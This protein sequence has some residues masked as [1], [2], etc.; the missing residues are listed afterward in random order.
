V[1][2][3]VTASVLVVDDDFMVAAVNAGYLERMPG[4]RVAGV[5][6]S[7]REA[8]RRTDELRPDLVL[9]DVYLPDLHGIEVLR[10]LREP[11]RH[12][13]DVL[14]V[15]AASDAATVRAAARHGVVSYLVKPFSVRTLTERVEA[16]LAARARLRSLAGTVCQDEVDA[17]LAGTRIGPAPLPKGLAAPTL[18][19]VTDVL[20]QADGDLSAVEV[21]E[22][23]GLSRVAARRYL[24]HLTQTDRAILSLRYGA[25]GRPEHRYR[26]RITTTTA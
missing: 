26:W 25:A 19:L 17:V 6:H 8:L 9:L 14:L 5:A 21:A 7:G 18:Q 4:V 23:A 2:A 22:R 16:W 24:E 12:Q 11:D 15:T 13:V 10:R 20:R 1:T 3:P